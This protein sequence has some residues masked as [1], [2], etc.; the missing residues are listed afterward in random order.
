MAQAEAIRGPVDVQ[1]TRKL[2][3]NPRRYFTGA[4]A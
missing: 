2:A 1:I 4:R 3:S